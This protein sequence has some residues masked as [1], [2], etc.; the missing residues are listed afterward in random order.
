MVE[1]E[2][3]LHVYAEGGSLRTHMHMAQVCHGT[4]KNSFAHTS[5]LPAEEFV[6]G[7]DLP[8]WTCDREKPVAQK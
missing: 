5:K 4:S 7:L 6:A 1:Q 2:T 8:V 3:P